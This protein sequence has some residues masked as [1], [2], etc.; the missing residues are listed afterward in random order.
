[1]EFEAPGDDIIGFEHEAKT[2]AQK[3]AAEKG[4]RQLLAPLALF[5]LPAGA[6][7]TVRLRTHKLDSLPARTVIQASKRRELA[8]WSYSG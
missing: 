4:K 8:T 6:G 7:C 3:T 2:P 5:K 1:M